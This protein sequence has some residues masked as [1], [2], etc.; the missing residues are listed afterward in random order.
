VTERDIVGELEAEIRPLDL[1]LKPVANRPVN[2]NDP[3]WMKK[4]E[5]MADPLEEA[6]ILREEAERLLLRIVEYYY[7]ASDEA[8]QRIRNLFERYR[9]FV[10]AVHLPHRP[11]T[12]DTFRQHLLLFS[13][14]DLGLDDRDAM[15]WLHD[16]CREAAKAGVDIRPILNEVAV[17]SSNR[18]KYG[19]SSTQGLLKEAAQRTG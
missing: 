11:V 15:V 1:R 2:M 8:R 13:I 19:S 9:A 12:N 16:L 4:L 14:D 10:W 7:H 3:A 6:G 17:L 18:K 5:S